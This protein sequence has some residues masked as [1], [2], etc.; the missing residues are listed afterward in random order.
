MVLVAAVA[1]AVAVVVVAI[2]YNINYIYIHIIVGADVSRHA[3][4]LLFFTVLS[5]LMCLKPWF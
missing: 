5:Q 2:E 1:V 3:E 4:F